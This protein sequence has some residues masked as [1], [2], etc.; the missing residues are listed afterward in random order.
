MYCGKIFIPRYQDE[1]SHFVRG[2]HEPLITE[3]LFN[4]VQEV[5]DDRGRTF[6]PKAEAEC[7]FPL[8]GYL[9]C[10]DCGKL[11]TASKSKGRNA[12]YAYYHWR[13]G[14]RHRNKAELV[15][16]AFRTEL[17]NF[18]PRQEFGAL[19]E[20]LLREVY[21]SRRKGQM[22]ERGE[23]LAQIRELEKRISRARDLVASAQIEPEDFREMKATY[24]AGIEKLEARLRGV[25]A[26]TDI[27]GLLKEGVERLMQLE[28][29]YEQGNTREKRSIIGAIF[30]EK[31]VFEENK[32][33][34]ARV[35]EVAQ[36]IYLINKEIGV[37]RNWTKRSKSA[38]SSQ[39]ARR[40]IEP[41]LPE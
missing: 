11:F 30:P 16:E 8:R 33:R 41:L 21:Y 18:V 26:K 29:Y 40:G 20:C 38:L 3:D 31:L 28:Y 32:V 1:E 14:G 5:L 19:Y 13:P 34:T 22:D 15:H 9:L 24:M 37:K 35:N 17:R 36:V 23:L 10:P 4:R 39:V 7:E 2:L 6:R 25:S 12:Y 27:E